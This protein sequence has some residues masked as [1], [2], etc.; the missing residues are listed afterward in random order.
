MDQDL[1]SFVLRF[2]REAGDD[3]QARWR[4]AVKH[5]QSNSEATFTQFSEALAFMQGYITD[6]VQDSFS[7]SG[8]SSEEAGDVNPFLE[9]TRL[10][11]EYMPRYT[12]MM[13]NTMGE[14]GR[15]MSKSMEQAMDST[16]AA[17]GMPTRTEQDRTAVSL[18]AMTKQLEA[19]TAKVADLENQ[20][21]GL[22]REA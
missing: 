6:I 19:L 7:K 20:I 16:R 9:T 8:R 15:E 1:V 3:Q 10:W 18:E 2:V 12:K 17:W 14:S 22:K 21:V 11:G 13:M 5:V 4:G